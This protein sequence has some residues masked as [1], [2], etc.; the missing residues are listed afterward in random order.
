MGQDPKF[1]ILNLNW[2]TFIH[3]KPEER[4][5]TSLAE[6]IKI[7]T[8]QTSKLSKTNLRSQA[9]SALEKTDLLLQRATP[10]STYDNLGSSY[11]HEDNDDKKVTNC[12][13]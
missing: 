9:S 10:Q 12:N 8:K 6:L 7:T 3:S 5:S 4:Q 1:R 13:V 11:N 2:L